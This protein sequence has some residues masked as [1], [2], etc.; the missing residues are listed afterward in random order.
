MINVT[1]VL[2]EFIVVF[3]T[4]NK[5]HANVAT[6]EQFLTNLNYILH[7]QIKIKCWA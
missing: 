6:K 4:T 5:K 3:Y 7:K 1:E 2:M